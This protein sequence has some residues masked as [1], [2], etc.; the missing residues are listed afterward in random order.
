MERGGRRAEKGASG[1]WIVIGGRHPVLEALAAGRA[2]REILLAEGVRE[3][4]EI[5]A[6]AQSRGIAARRLPRRTSMSWR[7]S[8]PTRESWPT[9]G[10]SLTGPWKCRSRRADADGPGLLLVVTAW[11][12]PKT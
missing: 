10:P 8:L 9:C 1:D 3:S 6:A 4:A 2:V 5:E 12:I 7:P 11:S